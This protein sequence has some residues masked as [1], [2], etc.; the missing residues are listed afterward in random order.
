MTLP[1]YPV[2][3]PS[4]PTSPAGVY[5]ASTGS[6]PEAPAALF[7]GPS[8]A[9]SAPEGAQPTGSVGSPSAPP[10]A[11]APG[12]VGSPTAP[13]AVRDVA[14]T[15]SGVIISGTMTPDVTGL[16]IDA[17]PPEGSNGISGYTSDGQTEMASSGRWTKLIWGEFEGVIL[18]S[19]LDGVEDGGW[20]SEDAGNAE[21]PTMDIRTVSNWI[22]FGSETIGLPVVAA[23]GALAPPAVIANASP[24]NPTAP[25]RPIA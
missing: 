19:Y 3:T 23:A 14:V 12:S 21:V 20:L 7:G 22:I 2:H 4:S 11:Q 24:T 13:G 5:D 17:G 18:L 9:P 1:I 15:A 8:G 25:G 16:L 6:S 10:A